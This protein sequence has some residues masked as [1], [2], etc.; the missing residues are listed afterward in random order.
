MQDLVS[1]LRTPEVFH[2][3]NKH[4]YEHVSTL[5]NCKHSESSMDWPPFSPD[6]TLVNIL[7]MCVYVLIESYLHG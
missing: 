5:E 7:C 1:P 3:F 4:S 2:F 6:M